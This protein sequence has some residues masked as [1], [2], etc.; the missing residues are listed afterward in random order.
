MHWHF[1]KF[2]ELSPR[3]I[4]DLYQARVA[5]FV[6]EQKCPFQMWTAPIRSAGISSAARAPEAKCSPIA[7]SFRR[8]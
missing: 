7:A 1:A 3:D 4:H 2:D 8:A 5:V 6:L